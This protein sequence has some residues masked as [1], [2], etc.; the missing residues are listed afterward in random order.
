MASLGQSLR[1]RIRKLASTTTVDQLVKRGVKQVNVVGLDHIVSL[2]EQAVQHSLRTKL[3]GLDR[4]KVAA[5]TREEFLRLLE[6]NEKLEKSHNEALERKRL[7]EEELDE[8]RRQH[9]E[10]AQALKEKLAQAEGEQR[11]RFEG[12]DREIA[13]RVHELFLAAADT[14]Q[15]ALPDMQARV[16]AMVLDLVGKERQGAIEAQEIAR[17]RE[18][19]N[20]QRRIQKL[21]KNLDAAEQHLAQVTA[22]KSVDGGI[23]SIYREV[24]GIDPADKL[25]D[26]K[27]E[28]MSE[29]F[30]ANIALQKG[31]SA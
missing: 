13:A 21:T 3:M 12:E 31:P 15:E 26:Q 6:R 17:D 27:K 23:S 16:T 28:L 1:A 29:I 18:V 10:A 22:M 11:A 20:L 8:L 4:Q 30:K 2:I 25:R 24:Q 14:G 19:D 9:R 5:A 7:A